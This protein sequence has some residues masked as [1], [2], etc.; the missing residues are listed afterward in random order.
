MVLLTIDISQHSAEVGYQTPATKDEL[1]SNRHLWAPH[2]SLFFA[3]QIKIK[4]EHFQQTLAENIVEG[5]FLF[6]FMFEQGHKQI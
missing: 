4:P 3:G 1:Q 5:K 6:L 2:F